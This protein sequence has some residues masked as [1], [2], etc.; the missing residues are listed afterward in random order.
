ML[1]STHGLGLRLV[2]NDQV[3]VYEKA[4]STLCRGTALVELEGENLVAPRSTVAKAVDGWE[5]DEK[6]YVVL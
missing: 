2:S 3:C 1:S 5:I 6:E 4:V